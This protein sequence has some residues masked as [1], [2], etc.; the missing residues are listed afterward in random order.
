MGIGTRLRRL[1]LAGLAALACGP[2]QAE[3]LP[4]TGSGN[5]EYVLGRLAEAFN[6]QQ[7]AHRVSVPASTGTAGALRDIRTGATS[8]ARVGRP[9]KAEEQAGGIRYL[10]VGRDPVAFVAGAGVSLRS[11]SPRQATDIF[12]GKLTDWRELGGKPGPIRA[13]GREPTDA[14]RQA[15]GRAIPAFADM[16]WGANVKLVHLDPQ[17]VEMLDR[18][19]TSVGFLNRSALGACRTA[20]VPLALDGVAPSAENLAAG[21]YP[22]WIEFGLIHREDGLT[23]AGK[24]FIEFIRSPAG[25]RILRDHGILPVAAP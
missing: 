21:R 8:L 15:V 13:I 10:P 22:V 16:A 18:Y 5:P 1:A 12:A 25:V 6:R 2:A 3:D 20:V 14:S 19:P 7:S 24:A 23:P 9:L 17:L 4:V 11:L